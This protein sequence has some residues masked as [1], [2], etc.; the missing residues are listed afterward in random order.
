MATKYPLE[1]TSAEILDLVKWQ[2]YV[3]T[4]NSMKL[5]GNGETIRLPDL[6]IFCQY[7]KEGNT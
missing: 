7:F 4:D 5:I 2:V 3:L 6:S 1:D